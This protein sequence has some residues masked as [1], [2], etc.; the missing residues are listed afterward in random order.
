MHIVGLAST[1]LTAIE[2]GAAT[3]C[4]PGMHNVQVTC[5]CRCLRS[6]HV[7]SCLLHASCMHRSCWLQ[8]ARVVASKLVA[9]PADAAELQDRLDATSSQLAA[10]N[11]S[12][13]ALTRQVGY[14]PEGWNSW[15]HRAH[16]R[17]L[18]P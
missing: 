13:E 10:A 9:G 16:R 14:L 11:G 18:I 1:C 6:M 12:T 8:D 17:C 5:I 15:S 3:A 4:S 7:R 2:A